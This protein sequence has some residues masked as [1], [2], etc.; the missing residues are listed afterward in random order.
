MPWRTRLRHVLGMAEI[1]GETVRKPDHGRPAAM[2]E[3]AKLLIRLLG[4]STLLQPP[5]PPQDG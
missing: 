5:R 2:H 3:L 4:H 1:A